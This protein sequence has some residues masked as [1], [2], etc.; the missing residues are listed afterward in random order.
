MTELVFHHY[1][2]SPFSEKIRLIFGLKQLHW[3][4]VVVPVIMPKPDL[5]ALT[6]GYRRTPVLQI[7]ADIYCDTLL[8]ADVL[9]RC[10]PSPSLY[11]PAQAGLARTL[12][13][14]ADAT[15]FWTA[16]AYA[17][18]PAGMQSMFAHLPPEAVQAFTADR[19]LLRGG[20]PRMAVAEATAQLT[21][22]LNRA[23][24]MLS[25]G[26]GFLLGEQPCIADFSV[27][28]ALWYVRRATAVAG[29]LDAAPRVLRWLD[30]VA[31]IG[32]HACEKMTGD[33]ALAI[34]AASD[35]ADRASGEAFVD[36]HGAGLGDRVVITPSDY[37]RDPVEGTLVVSTADRFALER[38]DARAGRVTVH[39]PRI[40]YQMKKV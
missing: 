31:A 9:E 36:Y 5:T 7:G 23:E 29:I 39:F 22:Y 20:A 13:Q 16:I 10:Q 37:G 38:T 18:Q 17:F 1:P 26:N 4:S 14:W 33:A 19:T 6:G 15:L 12:G 40:G 34:A 32:H 24:S 2:G 3:R 30:R 28:H 11:P 27:Y 21:L 35:G 25:A 8:I